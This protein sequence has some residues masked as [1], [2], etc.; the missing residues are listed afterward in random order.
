MVGR[1][2]SRKDHCFFSYAT[3]FNIT[4]AISNFFLD[5]KVDKKSRL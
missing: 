5:K 1:E 2:I 4:V 3:F